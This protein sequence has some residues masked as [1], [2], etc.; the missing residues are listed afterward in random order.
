MLCVA[1]FDWRSLAILDRSPQS[2]AVPFDVASRE[3]DAV[4]GT[5]LNRGARL[6]VERQHRFKAVAHTRSAER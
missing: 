3:L 1:A 2:K 4:L 5:A 6:R